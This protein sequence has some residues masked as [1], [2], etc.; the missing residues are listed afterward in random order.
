MPSAMASRAWIR[1]TKPQRTAGIILLETVI[2]LLAYEGRE[3]YRAPHER[4]LLEKT[5]RDVLR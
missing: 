1:F 3:G 2:Q 4:Y 5:L